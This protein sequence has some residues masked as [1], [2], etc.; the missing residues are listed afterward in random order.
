[1]GSF[2]AAACQ[3]RAGAD[4]RQAVVQ[5]ARS[6]AKLVVLPAFSLPAAHPNAAD[7]ELCEI[8]AD[9]AREA[10]CHLVAGTWPVDSPERSARFHVARLFSPQGELLGEQAQTHLTREEEAAGF[11]PGQEL[12]V[13]RVLGVGLG[14]VV[15]LDVRVPEVSRI[16]T[17]E[18]ATILV[19]PTA[20]PAPYSEDRQVAGLWREVQQNQIF[21]IEACL[22]GEWA[23]RSYAGRS[24]VTVACEAVPDFSGFVVR[25]PSA[26]QPMTVLAAIDLK[27]R[28]RGVAGFDFL[29]LLNIGLYKKYFPMAYFQRPRAPGRDPVVAPGK[30]AGPKGA[31][32]DD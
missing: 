24:A 4:P 20:L 17:L 27:A 22:V 6:G 25:A 16:L 1:M 10:G 19:A 29:G 28:E 14:L 3:I 12:R 30:P 13:L 2:I 21:G 26:D 11:R 18:G 5:A 31:T 7:P 23:G 9:L 8:A 32:T 15:G